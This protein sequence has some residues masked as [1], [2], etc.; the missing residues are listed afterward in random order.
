MSYGHSIHLSNA[1]LSREWRNVKLIISKY[2]ILG[3]FASWAVRQSPYTCPE[4][5]EE[6]LYELDAYL[7]GNME[8]LSGDF[9][10]NAMSLDDLEELISE[11]VFAGIPAI[12]RWNHRKNERPGMGFSDRYSQPIPDD[13]FV[14]LGALARNVTYGVFREA[15]LDTEPDDRKYMPDVE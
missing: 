12:E 15:L 11:E 3:E 4:N 14:D 1:G 6:A 8:R 7:V 13:D 10:C 5:F 9:Y 2:G